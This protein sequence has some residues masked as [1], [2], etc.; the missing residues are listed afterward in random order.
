[1]RAVN[2]NSAIALF[3]AFAAGPLACSGPAAPSGAPVLA[4]EPALSAIKVGQTAALRAV[5]RLPD[6]TQRTAA[7]A[8]WVS[9]AP[10]VIAV[11]TSGIV[12]ARTTGSASILASA[13]G[14]TASLMLQS[15]PDAGGNW[16]GQ[17][18]HVEHV[19]TSGAGPF[20]PATG[21]VRPISFTL[22]QEGASISGSG[23]VDLTPGGVEGTIRSDGRITLKGTF[24][25]AEGF[26]GEIAE[27]LIDLDGTGQGITGEFTIRELFVNAWGPQDIRSKRQILSLTR[28]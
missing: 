14:L 15:V 28:H 8:T 21:A 22:Q 11:D 5:Q 18:L 24:E 1:M 27:S 2:V 26:H 4:I 19:R 20:R 12:S 23:V 6:G 7:Q 13:D 16:S 17:T 25:N 9:N 10:A 3:V